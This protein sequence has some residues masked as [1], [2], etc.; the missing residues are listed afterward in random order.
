MGPWDLEALAD[1]PHLAPLS[2]G[3]H[4]QETLGVQGFLTTERGKKIPAVKDKGLAISVC[5]TLG[6]VILGKR[7]WFASHMLG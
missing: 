5:A 6:A 1:R 7:Q 3:Q 2:E 4:C